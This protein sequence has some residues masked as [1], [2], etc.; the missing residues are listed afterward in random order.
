VSIR[1]LK[2]QHVAAML[3]L[4]PVCLPAAMFRAMPAGGIRARSEFVARALRSYMK[5]QRAKGTP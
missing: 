2:R 4:V 3:R 5:Q 1:E